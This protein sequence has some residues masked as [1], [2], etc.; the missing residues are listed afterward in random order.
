LHSIR[1]CR[2]NGLKLALLE[3]LSLPWDAYKANVFVVAIFSRQTGQKLAEIKAR[4][5]MKSS[6]AGTR[7]D[8]FLFSARFSQN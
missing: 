7:D 1:E 3:A 5:L 4:G 2:W 8:V 6:L